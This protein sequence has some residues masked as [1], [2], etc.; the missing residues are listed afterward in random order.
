[1][2]KINVEKEAKKELTQKFAENSIFNID[3]NLFLVMCSG[4][5]IKFVK[6]RMEGTDE[7]HDQILGLAIYQGV[8]AEVWTYSQENGRILR[9]INVILKGG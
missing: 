1:M 5:A 8:C 9:E 6:V 7:K 3:K 2:K 4:E